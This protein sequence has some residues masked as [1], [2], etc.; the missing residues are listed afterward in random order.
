MSYFS[1][2]SNFIL[3]NCSS[4][5]VTFDTMCINCIINCIIAINVLFLI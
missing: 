4:T 2:T 1:Y 5:L 3:L